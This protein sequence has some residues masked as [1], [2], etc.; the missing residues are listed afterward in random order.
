MPN[1][2]SHILTSNHSHIIGRTDPITGDR[3]K[4]NDRVVFCTTCKSCFLKESWEYM[5]EVHCEQGSTLEDIPVAYSNFVVKK[6][7]YSP[8]YQLKTHSIYTTI[9]S[10]VFY[11]LV[12]YGVTINNSNRSLMFLAATAFGVMLGTITSL[13]IKKLKL[14]TV[15]SVCLFKNRIEI[16]RQSFFFDDVEQIKFQREMESFISS[17]GQYNT[18]SRTPTLFI[19]LKNGMRKDISFPTKDY[20]T[21]DLFLKGL[22]QVSNTIRISFYSEQSQEYIV[23]KQIAE[24]SKSN[25][26][27]RQPVQLL[28]DTLYPHQF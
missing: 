16:K 18:T 2:H 15:K 26:T 3:V 1:Y 6:E 9:F 14:L 25:I 4:E 8:I 21:V 24:N 13:I 10:P 27:V 12:I 17:N 11:F 28:D 7:K 22:V 20:K 5:K 19:Y 23:M